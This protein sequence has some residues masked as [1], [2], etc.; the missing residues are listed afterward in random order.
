MFRRDF[1]RFVIYLNSYYILYGIEC[2]NIISVSSSLQ[3]NW[4]NLVKMILRGYKSEILSC[5]SD[6]YIHNR[7]VFLGTDS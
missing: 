1:R 3:E 2:L 7:I 4:L 6:M 5:I